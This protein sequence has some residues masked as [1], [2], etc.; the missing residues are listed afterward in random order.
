MDTHHC[1]ICLG[2]NFGYSERLKAARC[3][4]QRFFSDIRFGMEMET[5]AIGGK[6]L[7]PFCNQLAI[8]TSDLS[9]FDIRLI[10]KRIEKENGR[11][12]E[13]KEKGVVKL[14]IDLLMVDDEVLKPEDMERDFVKKGLEEDIFI[15]NKTYF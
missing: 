12:P 15:H 10:L 5:E 13:D 7:S 14:D 11:L 2:S 9:A 8:F 4:L 1:L 6:W 3:A